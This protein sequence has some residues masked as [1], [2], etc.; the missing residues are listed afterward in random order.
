M[1]VAI[2]RW[3][4]CNHVQGNFLVTLLKPTMLTLPTM[5]GAT[6]PT[7]AQNADFA[8]PGTAAYGTTDGM[9][10]TGWNAEWGLQP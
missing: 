6:D 1:V 2:C 3:N 4:S 8:N 7:Q 10:M 5:A 9:V